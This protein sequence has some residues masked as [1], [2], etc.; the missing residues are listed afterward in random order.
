MKRLLL[1]S[2]L[3]LTFAACQTPETAEPVADTPMRAV[4]DPAAD[5]AEIEALTASYQMAE[6]AGD[7]AAIAAL[8]TDDAVIQPANKPA[9]RG[10]TGLDAYFAANDAEPQDITFTTN[11]VGV[12]D[13]GNMAYEVGTITAP[14]YAGKYLTVYRRTPDGWKIVAD[15]WSDDALPTPA[16]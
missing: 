13:D 4:S 14:D 12:S 9:V 11:D 15:S 2:F 7:H 1:L 3:A 6:R 10:R 8:Y 16:D 5:R